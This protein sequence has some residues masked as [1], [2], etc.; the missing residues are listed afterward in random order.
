[1]T[2][3]PP[4]APILSRLGRIAGWTLVTAIIV[5]SVVP[6]NLRPET[7]L[8]HALEHFAIYW[9]TG[10]AFALGYSFTPLLVTVL[11]LFSGVAEILQLFIPGRHARVS[12][13]IVDAL[14]SVIGLITVSLIV[15]MRNR[16]R[17]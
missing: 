11:V 1:L 16:T 9:A 7:D 6:P 3:T 14:A 15:Q 10:V 8:P 17:A 5:L 2:S 12:D 4:V 13:F